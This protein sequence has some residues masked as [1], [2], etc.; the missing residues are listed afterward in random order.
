M[1]VNLDTENITNEKGKEIAEELSGD[2]CAQRSVQ[3]GD[4]GFAL[5]IYSTARDKVRFADQDMNLV[6]LEDGGAYI[7]GR[8]AK[9]F[10]LKAGDEVTFSPYDSDESYTVPVV[11][12]LSSMSESVTMTA[13]YA[14]KAGIPYTI[15]AV[16][17][18]NSQSFAFCS[19]DLR[20]NSGFLSK[21]SGQFAFTQAMAFSYSSWS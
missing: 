14:D 19:G 16:F 5:E 9:E 1:K 8:I 2:W 20:I 3:I 6:P 12:I 11:G 4:R 21:P 17:T 18:V 7:C 10:G 15:S 13:E